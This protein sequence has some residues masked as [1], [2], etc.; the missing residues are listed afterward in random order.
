MNWYLKCLK[1]YIDFWGRARRKEYWMFTLWNIV[2]TMFLAALAAIGTE[3]GSDSSVS[4]IPM[5]L[6]LLY[7]LFI[8]IPSFTV[9]VR[10]LHDIGKSGWWIL[11]SLIPVIG[12]IILLVWYCTEGQRC[13]NEW[14]PDPKEGE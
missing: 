10:R 3:I 12:G 1:Q 5:V 2:I 14:G 4:Y 7:G 9:S 11:I 8:L 6:Y 13:E